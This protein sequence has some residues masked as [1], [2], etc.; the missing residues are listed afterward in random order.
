MIALGADCL[1][2][3]N[4]AGEAV[5]LSADMISVELSGDTS[6][7]MDEDAVKQAAK[8]VFHFFKHDLGRQT[9]TMAEFA[10]ALEK[11]LGTFQSVPAESDLPPVHASDLLGL[12]RE[13]AEGCELFFFPRLR[14][15]L[16][17]QLERTPPILRFSGLRCCVKQLTGAQR[18]TLE[19]RSLEDQIVRFLRECLRTEAGARNC[20]LVVE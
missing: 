20:S 1:V 6:K 16:K 3:E 10:E 9:V 11:A 2:F 19:C 12:A 15:E 5:P 14:D 8:A 18:W 17:K 13:S 7:C 4:S